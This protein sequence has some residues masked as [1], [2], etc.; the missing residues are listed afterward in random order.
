MKHISFVIANGNVLMPQCAHPSVGFVKSISTVDT[1]TRDNN[2]S[3][4]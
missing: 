1:Q 2:N 3:R 4:K